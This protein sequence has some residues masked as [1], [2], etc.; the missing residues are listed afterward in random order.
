MRILPE[1]RPDVLVSDIG[2]PGED[3]NDFIR[4]LR[5]AKDQAMA[6]LP[7]VAL[8]GYSDPEDQSRALSAGF[9]RFVP[10]P[11]EVD[12]LADVIRTLAVNRPH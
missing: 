6:G 5:A 8:T 2:M 9:Q 3:G 10:K 7:A 4:R 12:E 11:V 1:F